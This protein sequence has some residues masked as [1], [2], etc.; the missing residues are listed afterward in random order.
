VNVAGARPCRTMSAPLPR[1]AAHRARAVVQA[2][3][4]GVCLGSS[5]LAAGGQDLPAPPA[6]SAVPAYVRRGDEAEARYRAYTAR[7]ERFQ[8]ELG[9]EVKR[10]APD[11]YASLNAARPEPVKHGYQIVPKI[12]PGPG[13][14]VPRP[15]IASSSYSWR[16]TEEL[17]EAD[18]GR[19][20]KLEADTGRTGG[21]RPGERL[22]AWEQRVREFLKLVAHQKVIDSLIR[23][24]R[25]WQGEVHRLRAAYDRSTAL[26]D[27]VVE[28]QA[29][30]D[31]PR[32]GGG[33]LDVAARQREQ[34]LARQIRESIDRL[35][36]PDFIRFE[37]PSPHLWLIRVPFST[38]IE[39]LSF[40]HAF[41]TTVED[42]WRVQDGPDDLRVILDIQ[43]ITPEQL[44]AGDV[45]P[46]PGDPVDSVKHLARFP[47]DRGILTT[48]ASLTHVNGRWSINLGPHDITGRVLSHELGHIL[49]FP[50][51]YF[52][53][54]RDRGTEG[55]EVLEVITDP[56]DIMSAPGF[57]HAQRHHF[58][59]L[60]RRLG[61]PIRPQSVPEPS[62]GTG[63]GPSLSP[64][65]Q[66]DQR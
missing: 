62:S 56:E 21:L 17:V 25:L 49:G 65:G 27:A 12:V 28:R 57:G 58:E 45:P 4:L 32:P 3:C 39:D 19:L 1:S 15:K 2:L 47:A 35:T 34:A 6:P 26:H 54:Y 8:I 40:V 5:P 13:P 48:G 41:R 46:R 37:H 55:Y 9:N 10:D 24:N 42:T 14:D 52:R 22:A 33:P 7:L 50:D 51:G 64:D 29:I 18:R 53:G 60:L 16:R 59:A 23:Y 66:R 63:Q 11:L 38:D 61:A 20:E 44:Y 31:A 36:C 43:L 30:V